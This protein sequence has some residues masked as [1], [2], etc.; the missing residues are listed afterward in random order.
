MK[1][2]ELDDDTAR[3][4]VANNEQIPDEY[5]NMSEV[6]ME[7]FLADAI[8]AYANDQDIEDHVWTQPFRRAGLLTQDSGLVIHIGENEFQLRIVRTD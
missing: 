3:N 4:D 1:R 2:D 5:R 8:E 6:E 7:G